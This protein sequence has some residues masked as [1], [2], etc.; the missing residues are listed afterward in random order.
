LALLRHET[1]FSVVVIHVAAPG[2]FAHHPGV[3]PE[4]V[5]CGHRDRDEGGRA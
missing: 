5:I 1:R 2:R 4:G 3:T